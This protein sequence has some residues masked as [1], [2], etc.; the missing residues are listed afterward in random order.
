VQYYLRCG[1]VPTYYK[2]SCIDCINFLVSKLIRVEQ[3]R[4]IIR[5]N[6]TYSKLIIIRVYTELD[7]HFIFIAY[8]FDITF[9]LYYSISI[10]DSQ[11]I[12][13]LLSRV[14]LFNIYLRYYNLSAHCQ[15]LLTGDSFY[16]LSG[17]LSYEP[18]H[19]TWIFMSQRVSLVKPCPSKLG[20]YT[21]KCFIVTVHLNYCILAILFGSFRKVKTQKRLGIVIANH[22]NICHS[23]S[24]K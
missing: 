13:Y 14:I 1:I 5:T 6:R 24:R 11:Y 20:H 8:L 15:F 22:N 3:F 16:R 7:N 17:H 4:K 9:S 2:V 21:E 23:Y 10:S 12:D 18:L 19:A